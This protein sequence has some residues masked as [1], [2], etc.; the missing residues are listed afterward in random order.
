MTPS[1]KGAKNTQVETSLQGAVDSPTP[2]ASPRALVSPKGARRWTSGHPW[3]YRSDVVK[4]PDVHAGAV[5]VENAAGAPLGWAL[6]SPRSEISLR[7]LDRS[8]NAQ[9]DAR[10]WRAR[11]EGAIARRGALEDVASAFRL[12]HGEADGCPSLVC[13]RYDRWLVVQLLSAGIERFRREIVESLLALVQPEG[14]LARNDVPVRAKEGLARETVLLAG[15]VPREIEVIEYGLRYLAAPWDGQKTG[16]FL[17]Q[18]E[19]RALAGAIARGRAL[20][21][22]SYHGS[23]ALH[24]ARQAASVTALDAS[25]PALARARENAARNAIRN[26]EFIE[27]DAFEWLRAAERRR[28]RF[29]T[30][31]LDPPAFAK[32]RDALSSA[33]RGY[34]EINLRAMRLLAPGGMLF[35]ASCSYHLTKALF[36]EVLEAAAADSGRRIALRE[37]RGQPL[38]HPEVLTIP[39]TGY[40]KGALLEALD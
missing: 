32:T 34:K 26:I 16:A 3:I 11:L 35:T 1:Q 17:D 9:I 36:L 33:L 18:R 30:I 5:L 13:D 24:L 23:F 8:P 2:V 21:C 27:A 7:L 28:E 4:R 39:E 25:A 20:D 22:F 10:W 38:D 6:W 37:M 29:D 15:D 40:I 12:V 19:N 14:I 31:V